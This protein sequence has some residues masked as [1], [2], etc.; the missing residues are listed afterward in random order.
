MKILVTGTTGHLGEAIA[1]I[2]TNQN[3]EY[4]GVDLLASPYTTHV[5]NICDRS[6]VQR[7][8]DGVDAIIHTA[9]LHKPH[10]A[11]HSK[12]A[13]VDTN[14]SGTLNLLEVAIA[15]G[16]SP[17]IFTSTTSTFGDRLRPP[18]GQPASWITEEVSPIPKNIYGAT[19]CAA[20]DLCQL[21]FRNHQLPC[22]ILK[23][24]RF[25]LEN[26]D[27]KSL[28]DTYQDENL[29]ANEFLYRRLDLEDAAL[30]HLLALEKAANIGFAKY[31]LSASSPFRPS[32]LEELNRDAPKVVERLFPEYREIYQKLGWKMFP[33]IDRVYVNE[34]ARQ[35]LG[36][37][38]T[39]DFSFVLEQVKA[40]KDF[41]SPIA[42]QVGT[43]P[44]HKEIFSEG[45]YPVNE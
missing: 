35:D 4:V 8:M 20:E 29:K 7:A 18:A 13:F 25:F 1:R 45:P 39:Y 3:R 5:G 28:R 36:W 31:I 11:T 33:R 44:Y 32:D 12:Q 24:S 23:T 21:F 41:L 30:A 37:N 10:V 40:H 9:T 42:R 19:K 17:F 22:L 15:H 27:K 16:I 2:L 34:K 14:I 38:P 26:D 43:K 6:F